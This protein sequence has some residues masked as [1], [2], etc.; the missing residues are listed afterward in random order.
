MFSPNQL[1]ELG[2]RLADEGPARHER[3]LQEIACAVAD[4]AP[5][6][7]AALRDRSAAEV[8]REQDLPHRGGGEPERR[9][10]V[11]PAA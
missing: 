8:L 5:G 6:V 2:E 3:A 9:H 7:A 10:V 11:A 1:A 4:R